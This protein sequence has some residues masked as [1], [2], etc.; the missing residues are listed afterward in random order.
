MAKKFGKFLAL[1]AVVSAAAGAVYYYKNKNTRDEDFDDLDDFEDEDDSEDF[2]DEDAEAK[3]R[4]ERSFKDIFPINISADTVEEAKESIKK[5]VM[6]IG[7]KL[8]D[9]ADAVSNAV[10]SSDETANVVK[11]E[12]AVDVE[13]FQFYDLS[14]D[15][16]EFLSE[17]ELSVDD[18]ADEAET[19]AKETSEDEAEKEPEQELDETFID[20]EAEEDK[21]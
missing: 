20:A 14:S 12:D 15:E 3:E 4:R 9:A 10:K 1:A 21:L 5:V 13:D 2:V 7:D 17:E 8:T 6:D 11:S 16:E 18:T 19:E